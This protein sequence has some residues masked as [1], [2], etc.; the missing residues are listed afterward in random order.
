MRFVRV[1]SYIVTA[2][3]KGYTDF[4]SRIVAKFEIRDCDDDKLL[5][6]LIEQANMLHESLQEREVDLSEGSR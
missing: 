2:N 6:M 3:D 4:N 1:L 5:T